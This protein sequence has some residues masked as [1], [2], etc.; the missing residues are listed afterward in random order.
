MHIY[1]F[2]ELTFKSGAVEKKTCNG[3]GVVSLS[4][5]VKCNLTMLSVTEPMLTETYG[6]AFKKNL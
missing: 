5:S 2:V 3:G 4:L 1:V 6:A